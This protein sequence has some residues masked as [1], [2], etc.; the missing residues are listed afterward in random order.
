MGNGKAVS[1]LGGLGAVPGALAVLGQLVEG[2]GQGD[3]GDL[4]VDGQAGDRLEGDGLS[5]LLR[6][7]VS[8][9]IHIL[10]VTSRNSDSEW[11]GVERGGK[12]YRENLNLNV[13]GKGLDG[14][15]ET[16]VQDALHGVVN[17]EAAVDR[18]LGGELHDDQAAGLLAAD[19]DVD[20]GGAD[21]HLGHVDRD[22]G[23]VTGLDEVLDVGDNVAQEVARGVAL[24]ARV[25][26]VQL[27]DDGGDARL[28]LG[29]GLLPVLD[30][31]VRVAHALD[32]LDRV[33]RVELAV[34]LVEG[35]QGRVGG[36]GA[37]RLGVEARLALVRG[38]EEGRRGHD[39]L[40][41]GPHAVDLGVVHEAILQ[42]QYRLRLPSVVDKMTL[43]VSID[44]QQ[45]VEAGVVGGEELGAA[46]T[47]PVDG[48][49]DLL[50]VD[51]GAAGGGE[52]GKVLRV[53]QDIVLRAALCVSDELYSRG[54]FQRE[55]G[56]TY[57]PGLVRTGSQVGVGGGGIALLGGGAADG[58][59]VASAGELAVRAGQ[60]HAREVV[61]LER[62]G[63]VDG[64]GAAAAGDVDLER[65]G[66]GDGGHGAVGGPV[67]VGG[68]Q[69]GGGSLVLGADR[70]G[71]RVG[72]ALG[73]GDQGLLQRCQLMFV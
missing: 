34:G 14:V 52:V 7:G 18:A 30:A 15:A 40:P 11:S 32:A 23:K 8:K 25:G 62:V 35:L 10:T 5:V 44:L 37:A 29:L 53:G 33:G 19:V 58:V 36:D 59:V 72:D 57:D 66:D 26:P 45:G 54:S 50:N 46:S 27:V 51:A 68:A 64:L 16:T 71:I 13:L 56:T 38:R 3:V 70:R 12:T 48:V 28:D 6:L 47:V 17:G 1:A 24:L 39:G 22:L 49:V 61:R 55:R 65:L 41:E 63:V 43:D 73:D 21:R 20:L 31:L 60:G 4:E 67:P 69:A 2:G 9:Q 42:R